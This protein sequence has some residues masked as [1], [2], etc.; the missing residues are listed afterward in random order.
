MEKS[1]CVKRSAPKRIE[2]PRT[3][4]RRT[5]AVA[6]MGLVLHGASV[7]PAAGQQSV[8][9]VLS[10]LLTN[11]SIQTKDFQQDEQAAAATRDTIS[12]LLLIELA[13][14]PISSSA[15]GFTY[16]LNPALG[17]FERSSDSF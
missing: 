2:P 6:V 7:R 13:T 11:R 3:R 16:R 15:S 5:A 1:C 17:T 10:F 14:L 8:T 4:N 9:D 12:A